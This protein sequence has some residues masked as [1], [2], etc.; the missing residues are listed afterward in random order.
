MNK[1]AAVGS[2]GWAGTAYLL[3]EKADA[4]L[5]PTPID[6]VQ[7]QYSAA[8]AILAQACSQ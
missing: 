7:A 3:F 1:A 2:T 8:L 6:L 4:Y 5:N